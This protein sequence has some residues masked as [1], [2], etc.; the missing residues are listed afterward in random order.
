[1]AA[2]PRVRLGGVASFG[3]AFQLLVGQVIQPAEDRLGDLRG[4]VVRPAPNLRIEG[5]DECLVGYLSMATYDVSEVASLCDR[6]RFDDGLEG[7]HGPVPVRCGMGPTHPE[8]PDVEA[9][10]VKSH[11]SIVRVER[12]G[13]PGLAELQLQPHAC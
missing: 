3:P 6:A 5:I 11:R 2:H 7:Q 12:V 13:D 8:L 4:V 9:Q 1:M 10:E